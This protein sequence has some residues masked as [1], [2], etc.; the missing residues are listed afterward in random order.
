MAFI[1][2][3]PPSGRGVRLV[4]RFNDIVAALLASK[5][6]DAAVIGYGYMPTLNRGIAAAKLKAPAPSA[7]A[8]PP[9]AAAAAPL[10]PPE[11]L[12]ARASG[13]LSGR[14]GGREGSEAVLQ[15]SDSAPVDGCGT[16]AAAAAT[17]DL[18][19]C[20]PLH[21]AAGLGNAE[22][23]RMLLQHHTA[24]GG[25]PR[26]DPDTSLLSMFVLQAPLHHAVQA[27][28]LECVRLLLQHGH[29]VDGQTARLSRTP[30]HLAAQHGHA[31][32]AQ[33]LLEHGVRLPASH[34]A[35]LVVSEGFGS[36]H[37][38]VCQAPLPRRPTPWRRRARRAASRAWRRASRRWRSCSATACPRRQARTPPS[39]A[40]CSLLRGRGARRAC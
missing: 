23:V 19:A 3:G 7:A 1:A 38:S 12:A 29:S 28:S 33:L 4:C 17:A 8:P 15:P 9:V 21:L 22:A 32:I 24:G 39:R 11:A 2:C 26:L 31:H 36:V 35:P 5:H 6:V 16:A 20:M 13:H 10:P 30:L 25:P 34:G 18:V 37:I 14:T 27:G 40:C